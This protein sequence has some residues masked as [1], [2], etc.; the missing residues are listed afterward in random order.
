M[1]IN[2]YCLDLL[3]MNVNVADVAFVYDIVCNI[4]V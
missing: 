2:Y 1:Y 3:K 4:L